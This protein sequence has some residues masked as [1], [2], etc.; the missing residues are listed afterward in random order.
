MS[1][2]PVARLREELIAAAERRIAASAGLQH[3]PARQPRVRRSLVA[4]AIALA[5]LVL[6]AVALAAGLISIGK[7]YRPPSYIHYNTVPGQGLGVPLPG[8]VKVLPLST[9]D[10]HGGAPWGMRYLKTTRGLGCLQVGRLVDGQI[11]VLGIDGVANDDGRFHALPTNALDLF[12]CEPLDA[13]GLTLISVSDPSAY[14]YGTGVEQAC[15]GVGT[16]SPSAPR[17]PEA[18]LRAVYYGLLGPQA[19]S[20]TY[21]ASGNTRTIHPDGPLGGYL[22]VLPTPNRNVN[23]GI[24]GVPATP[25]GPPFQ[26]V[27]F[28]NGLVCDLR[29]DSAGNVRQCPAPG[30]T[31]IQTS[32]VSSAQIATPITATVKHQNG[33]WVIA[34]SFTARVAVTNAQSRYDLQVT[35]PPTCKPTSVYGTET[36]GN[37]NKG[38]TV[39]LSEALGKCPGRY[40]AIVL[41]EPSIQSPT[42]GAPIP[43]LTGG[44]LDGAVVVGRVSVSIP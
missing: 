8:S 4:L 17:C 25:Y 38:E 39:Q 22:I 19:S 1:Q 5:A 43:A 9:P 10:L 18:D 37:I 13:H 34:A 23:G 20:L 12:N 32:R 35:T 3:S 7:P 31:P 26:R 16:V 27:T 2:E 24:G 6:A 33:Y 36:P 30:F 14:A 15:A 21:T 28:T 42:A 40:T 44:S 41:Y 29:I 11:G